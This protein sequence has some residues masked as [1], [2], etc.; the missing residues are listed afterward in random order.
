MG[1]STSLFFEESQLLHGALLI[2]N[3]IRKKGFDAF[4]VGG[5]V[6]DSLLGRKVK[7][8]DIVTSA[9]PSDIQSMFPS[10]YNIGEAFGIVNVVESSINYEV[11][12]YRKETLYED[13][14]HPTSVEYARTPKEDALRRDFT[15]NAIYYDPVDK[16]LLDFT[17]GVAD[18]KKGII[19]AIG[20]AEER[21]SEDYLRILRAVRFATRFGFTIDNELLLSA[22]KLAHN[23][24]KLSGERIRDELTKIFTGTN[25]DQA[26]TLLDETGLLAVLLPEISAMKGIAQPE[27]YHPE[28]DVF[29]HTRLMLSNMPIPS[30]ELAWAIILHDVGKPLTFSIGADGKEKFICH[31]EKGT[32]IAEQILQRL[33]F[34]TKFINN[35]CFAVKNHMRFASVTEMR[36]SKYKALIA[37]PT[38]PLELE[39]HRIDCMSSNKFTGSFVFLLDK[40]IEQD[41]VRELPE[42]L[43]KG[44]NLIELGFIPGPQFSKILEKITELQNDKVINTRVDA[45]EYIKSKFHP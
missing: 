15:I 24:A 27:K 45:I 1:M 34:P 44:K 17:G 28:G 7:D 20:K 38:F 10:T 16:K 39:L 5:C 32:L 19:R 37:E 6:R 43:I 31:A 25:P 33:K 11:A 36:P 29:E 9:L 3:E 13:G 41:G 35:V 8:I 12:T 30:E 42:P 4:F 18:L 23:T 2:I 14:R 22:R 26:L 21:F 40:L